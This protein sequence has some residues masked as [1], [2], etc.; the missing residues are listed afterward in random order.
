MIP[1][2]GLISNFK[3]RV[4]YFLVCPIYFKLY[5]L[6]LLQGKLSQTLN[7]AEQEV[8]QLVIQCL[9]LLKMYMMILTIMQV[10]YTYSAALQHIRQNDVHPIDE[11]YY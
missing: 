3:E 2:L 9:S 4:N 10:L 6:Y 11:A 8:D 7:N 5:L 1:H